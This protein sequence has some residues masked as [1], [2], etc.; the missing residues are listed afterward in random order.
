MLYE[1]VFVLVCVE[2]WCMSR[3][4]AHFI[5]AEPEGGKVEARVDG[6]VEEKR[7]MKKKE[8]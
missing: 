2:C 5:S 4:M 8:K 6:D 3:L 7:K 1:C